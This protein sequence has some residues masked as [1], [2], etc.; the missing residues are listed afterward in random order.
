MGRQLQT[1]RTM[2]CSHPD[3]ILGKEN[4]TAE[5]KR[6]D[7][8]ATPSGCGLDMEA[9]R[10]ILE[11]RLQLIVR[12]RPLVFRSYLSAQISNWD[13]ISVIGKLTKR[14][15][16]WPSGRPRETFGRTSKTVRTHFRLSRRFLLTS[17]C[18][19]HN[20][21]LEYRI[22]TKLVSLES[23]EKILQFICPENVRTV[24]HQDGK[25]ALSRRPPDMLCFWS[26]SL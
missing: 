3:A 9:F 8:R 16:T 20:S 4:C 15:T 17:Q 1:V 10:A 25:R 19:Y 12:T 7:A 18:F 22:E 26:I 23:L 21:L 14:Y 6:S 5:V 24:G 11:R 2:W 13:E